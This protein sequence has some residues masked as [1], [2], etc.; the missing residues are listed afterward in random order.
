MLKPEAVAVA[1][2]LAS[3]VMGVLLADTQQCSII[4]ESVQ[5]YNDSIQF[6]LNSSDVDCSF[7]V[8]VTGRPGNSTHCDQ[9]QENQETFTCQLVELEPGTRYHLIITSQTDR[10]QHNVSL[11]TR[12]SAVQGVQVLRQMDSLSMSWKPGPGRAE[13]FQVLLRDSAGLELPWNVTM[14]DNVT[15]SYKMSGL[16]PGRVYNVSIITEAAGMRNAVHIQER[17]APS[18]VLNAHMENKG[19]QTGLQV[20]WDPATGDVDSYLIQLLSSDSLEREETLSPNTTQA[21]FDHLTPGST[22][23]AFIY[24]KSGDLSSHVSV[25]ATTAPGAVSQLKMEKPTSYG[26]VK[27]SWLP[28]VGQWEHYSIKLING[29]KTLFNT[30]IH[31]AAMEFR[32]PELHLHP[33]K[34]YKVAVST[35]SRGQTSTTYCRAEIG[36]PSVSQ[37]HIR[38]ADET[39]LSA[40]W[41]HG[42]GSE[43]RDAYVV[44]LYNATGSTAIKTERLTRDMQEYTFNVLVPGRLYRIVVATTSGDL[45]NS[46]SVTGRTLPHEVTSLRLN[47]LRSTDSLRATWDRPQGDLDSY[48]VLLQHDNQV[49]FNRSVPA[50]TTSIHLSHLKPGALYKL[51]IKTVSGE[52]RAKPVMAN[53]HTVPAGVGEVTVTNNGRPDFLNVSWKASEGAVD[54]YQIDL[55]D[56]ERVVYT[57]TKLSSQFSS[58]V[59]GR[60]YKLFISACSGGYKNTTVFQGR[61]QPSAVQNPSAIHLAQENVLKVYWTHAVG[62]YDHY[63]VA[64]LHNN[65]LL[66]KQTVERSKNEC[67]FSGLVSGRLYTLTISTWSGEYESTVSTEG[68]TFPAAVRFPVLAQKGTTH[69]CVSWKSAP[70]DVDHYELQIFNNDTKLFSAV[71]LNTAREHCFSPLSPGFR[72]KIVVSTISGSYLNPQAIEGRTV[73]SQV[74][75]LQLVPGTLSGSLRASW[76]TGAGDMD[77]YTVVLLQNG[78][79]ESNRRVLKQE[80]RTDFEDLVP[81]ELYTVRVQT[82]SGVL[83]NVSSV[84]ARTVPSPVKGLQADSEDATRSLSV[85]WEAPKGV[86]DGYSLQLLDEGDVM[87]SNASVPAGVKHHLFEGLVPGT[88]YTVHL[89]TLSNTS[90]S[91]D[92]IAKGQTRPAAVQGLH[93][94]SNSTAELTFGWNVSKG[95]VD[96]YD[97]RLY[98]SDNVLQDHKKGGAQDRSCIFPHLL[99]GMLYKLV[100]IS[101]SRG[102]SSESSLWARTVPAPVRDLQMDHEGHMDRVSL[103]WRRAP[104]SLSGYVISLEGSDQPEQKLGPEDTHT[105]FTNLQPGHLY[106]AVLHSWSGDLTNTVS[107]AGRT[108]P[109]P[110][111]SLSIKDVG[112]GGTVEVMWRAPDSVYDDFEVKWLPRDELEMS[113]P[114]LE[115]RIMSGLYPGRLYNISLSTVSGGTPGPVT[116]SSVVYHTIRTAP[117]PVQSLHCHPLSS[118]SLSCSWK[119][120]A[121]DYSAYF[122]ECRR[123]GSREP[124]YNYTLSASTQFQHFDNLE[125]FRNYTISIAVISGDKKGATVQ[126][127]T[128]TMIDRP[129]VPQPTVRISEKAAHI[130]QSTIFFKFN[131]SW[132]SDTNGAIRYFAIV[133]AETDGME[134]VL[135]EHRHPL[136]SYLDYKRNSSVL[137]YQ[138]SYFQSLC[139]DDLDST[140]TL[141]E[142]N[143]GAGMDRLGGACEEEP[144]RQG[145]YFCDGP[146]KSRTAY[147]LSVRAF[148]QLFDDENREMS[149]PLFSDTYLSLPLWTQAEP[150]VGV[151]E[152]ISAALFL[153]GMMIAVTALLIFRQR[154]RKVAVQESPL[155]RMSM[156]KELPTSGMYVGVRS[157][158]RLSSPIKAAHFEAHLGKLQA[159]SNYLLSEEFEDL[160]DVGR[161]QTLDAAR[162]PENRCKNRYNNILPYDA[163]RVKLSCLEDDPSS[164]Y[165]NASFMPG[166]NFRREYIATQG[167]L[168]GTKDDFWRMVWE[169]NV[170][171][172]VMVTQCVE[173]GRVKCDQYWPLDREPLYYGDLVVHMLS[174]SVLSEWTIR[175]FKIFCEGQLSYPRIVRHFHY[176][177]WPDHGVP[178]TTQS[179]VQFVRTVRDYIDR[180]S[181]SGPTVVHCSAGVGRTGTFIVLDRALQQLDTHG[182]VDIYG[183]VFD[184]RL[185]RSHMVQTESQYVYLH[186]CVRDVLRARKLR[187]ETENPLYPIYENIN[188]NFYRDIVYTGK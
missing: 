96:H 169:Q 19:S 107:V 28:P 164:D 59:P 135:P 54:G 90:H 1:V 35:E 27:I 29:S 177:V 31:K 7:G 34:V 87:I 86:Y 52:L 5:I 25:T 85:S 108:V 102:M 161:N 124:V 71:R 9:D 129:P 117:G 18:L 147:R 112:P 143:L 16:T 168:P 106:T 74:Q 123:Q 158:R 122:M 32:F 150:L 42:F 75:N 79:V 130:T 115:R 64:I 104:G 10:I 68:R 83:T 185:H 127:S 167:P 89:K 84:S 179:L 118:K 148:T 70:G 76:S 38:H 131:C 48:E 113:K 43:S 33:G 180:V 50:D 162:L 36:P 153:I 141:F 163:T 57:A 174:E 14:L 154:V 94:L 172:V 155:V 182:T 72:Y 105:T 170:H 173:K 128:F 44:A 138:T 157:N 175:E 178:E 4:P 103:S 51:M 73:P 49:T 133:I 181:G 160:K 99:P 101:K 6:T 188:P 121:S 26:E 92:V 3:G 120:P 151:V 119:P 67:M 61:T 114:N 56:R 65:T 55:K 184:L 39:T 69:L 66:Q 142:I 149:H 88:I 8:N 82:V 186:Q 17:T 137:A 41:N 134:P 2:W 110:P 78:H 60:L 47:N 159:D 45:Q 139:G 13:L 171:N 116:Y 165:I 24:T 176:T 63:T 109:E 156:W 20:S 80:N 136:P 146:L 37:L 100:V 166:N 111:T 58:L 95:W 81:G 21:R 152:G 132:F 11:A 22:Y 144:S 98:S 46:S 91:K 12:P 40:M 30:T 187:C 183:C 15:K 93:L 140:N 23:Q 125:P 53:C 77:F 145:N 97:L 62:D 126:N